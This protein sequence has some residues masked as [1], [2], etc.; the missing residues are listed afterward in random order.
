MK[1][2][3]KL[4]LTL[5]VASLSLLNTNCSA[6]EQSPSSSDGIVAVLDEKWVVMRDSILQSFSAVMQEEDKNLA[7]AQNEI[8]R[9]QDK[10]GKLQAENREL[11]EEIERLRKKVLRDD[12]RAVHDVILNLAEASKSYI[13]IIY[14]KML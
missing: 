5:A 7:K 2:N 9:L 13:T 1:I 14:H 4:L 3:I 11:C 12:L 6:M 10:N 8:R